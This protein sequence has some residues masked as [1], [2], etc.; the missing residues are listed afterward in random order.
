MTIF[1]IL[2]DKTNWLGILYI[3]YTTR[4]QQN[5]I[6]STLFEYASRANKMNGPNFGQLAPSLNGY[7]NEAN[8]LQLFICI[9]DVINMI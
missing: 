3:P 4:I 2:K 1:W 8:I 5:Y 7:R 9:M 6:I